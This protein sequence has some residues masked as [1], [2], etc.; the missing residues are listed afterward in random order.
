[1]LHRPLTEV[2]AAIDANTDA[3]YGGGW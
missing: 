1:V 3:A 2:C